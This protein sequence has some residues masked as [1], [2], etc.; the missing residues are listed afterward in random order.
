MESIRY[1]WNDAG[2]DRTCEFVH[3]RGTHGDPYAFGQA[4][5]S[6][7]IEVGDFFIG[8]VPVTQA[9]W[10]HVMKEN[11]SPALNRGS[12]LPLEN[13]SWNQLTQP[14]GF[15]ERLNESAVAAAKP[16]QHVFRLPS[17]TEWEYAARGGPHWRDG[18]R[19]SGSDE[20]ADVAWL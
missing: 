11:T 8:A 12:D 3:V 20:I 4:P 16:E 19:F 14:G 7:M 9:L 15:L 2:V 10:R 1:H 17:E 5:D 18:F 6:R 13:V